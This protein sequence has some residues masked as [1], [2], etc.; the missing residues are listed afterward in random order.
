MV[1]GPRLLQRLLHLFVHLVKRF[2]RDRV[3]AGPDAALNT[4]DSLAE[5]KDSFGSANVCPNDHGDIRPWDRANTDSVAQLYEEK[6]E[7][8]Q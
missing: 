1:L 7:E 4:T 3:R 6:Q 2:Q 5:M 8:E